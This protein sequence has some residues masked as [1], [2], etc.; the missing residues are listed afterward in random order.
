VIARRRWASA[1]EPSSR[2]GAVESALCDQ[3]LARICRDLGI[4]RAALLRLHADEQ[5]EKSSRCSRS[6]RRPPLT[7]EF[8]CWLAGA[9]FLELA[10]LARAAAIQ[11]ERGFE[12][13]KMRFEAGRR[14]RLH[15]ETGRGPPLLLIRLL[16]RRRPQRLP[17]ESH[18]AACCM[19]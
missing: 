12:C 5:R 13:L 16:L 15:C 3:E 6:E 4:E 18:P 9:A 2:S 19:Q 8:F 10:D 14:P 17:R 1:P 11:A 7:V